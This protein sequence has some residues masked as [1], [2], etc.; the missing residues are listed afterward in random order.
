MAVFPLLV[1]TCSPVGIPH[2]GGSQ[3]KY[4]AVSDS[5][6]NSPIM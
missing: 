4:N 1:A 2:F 5:Q 6:Y 3:L